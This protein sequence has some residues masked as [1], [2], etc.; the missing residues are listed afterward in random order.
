[1]YIC[2]DCERVFEKPKHYIQTH[3]LS[4]T[5]YEHPQGCPYCKSSF[6]KTWKCVICTRYIS[7][8][9]ARLK[10]DDMIC[11]DCYEIKNIHL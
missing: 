11:A 9:Y 10:N 7:G 2:N 3:G 4:E 6:S 5:P 8:D 1:M